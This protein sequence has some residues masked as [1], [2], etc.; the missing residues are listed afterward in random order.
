M[1][2]FFAQRKGKLSC[3]TCWCWSSSWRSSQREQC[4]SAVSQGS[5]VGAVG[6]ATAGGRKS[7][8]P[9]PEDEALWCVPIAAAEQWSPT[10][11]DASPSAVSPLVPVAMD[12]AP[13][14]TGRI[15]AG[16]LEVRTTRTRPLCL[17]T[18]GGKTGARLGHCWKQGG[19]RLGVCLGKSTNIL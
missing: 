5:H 19:W 18:D 13:P 11:N 10:L 7:V 17:S 3:W 14:L 16:V 15:V 1:V 12:T 2:E 8:D 9:G 4:R 6:A